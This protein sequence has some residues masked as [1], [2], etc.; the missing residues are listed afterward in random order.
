VVAAGDCDQILKP[1]E[2]AGLVRGCPDLPIQRLSTAASPDRN[3]I[4]E[5][6]GRLPGGPTLKSILS[7]RS[8][9]RDLKAEGPGQEL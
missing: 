5:E 4:H 6:C 1:V 2:A 8:S 3:V 7:P 9:R